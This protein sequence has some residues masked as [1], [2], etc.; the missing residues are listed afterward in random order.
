M[1]SQVRRLEIVEETLKDYFI[2]RLRNHKVALNRAQL[3]LQ[4]ETYDRIL[5]GAQS[6]LDNLSL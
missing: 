4:I 2:E 3:I 1:C 6:F 5:Q